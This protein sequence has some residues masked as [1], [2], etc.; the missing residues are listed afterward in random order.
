MDDDGSALDRLEE[1]E[2]DDKDAVQM[3]SD[4]DGDA[5]GDDADADDMDVDEEED[6]EDNDEEDE[7]DRDDDENQDENDDAVDK[8]AA[9]DETVEPDPS[10]VAAPSPAPGQPPAQL[11]DTTAVIDNDPLWIYSYSHSRQFLKKQLLA[12]VDSC[13]SYD[14]APYVAA[15]MSTSI[16]CMD[17]PQS[18][19]WMFTGGQDGFIRK[20]DFYASVN[21]KLQLTVAQKHPF[22][23][24]ITK[25]G[26]LMSYWEN[27]IPMEREE[28]TV[29]GPDE[30][31][32]MRISPVYALA[33][34]S[35]CLWLLS[36][37]ETGGITLQTV[38][39][40]EGRIHE[41]LQ[42]HTSA[43]SVLRLN[44]T[45]TAVISGGWDK[46]VF[47]WD[48]NTG[49]V[50]RSYAGN[51]G[52]ISVVAWRP[53]VAGSTLSVSSFPGRQQAELSRGKESSGI[54]SRSGGADST[55]ALPD[56]NMKQEKDD[57]DD[58]D[59]MG[60]LFGDD[61][62]EEEQQ[63]QQSHQD[64]EM[65]DTS[66]PSLDESVF[67]NGNTTSAMEVDRD[68]KVTSPAESKTN[69]KTNG[70]SSGTTSAKQTTTSKP[71]YSNG[72]TQ[73]ASSAENSDNVFLTASIDG[74]ARLWDRRAARCISEIGQKSA[75]PPWCMNACWS[76]DGN[77]IYFGRRNGVV[78]EYSLHA[79]LGE[80]V[81]TL[82]LP[83]GS[84]PVSCV[85]P[86]PNARHLVCAS[87][88]NIRLYDLQ[89]SLAAGP[90]IATNNF[91]YSNLNSNAAPTTAT[92]AAAVA[93]ASSSVTSKVPFLIVPGH[94]GGTIS[95]ILI[96]PTC[97]YM[98]TAGGNRGWEGSPTEV[99]LVYEIE[100]IM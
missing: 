30:L 83:Q 12:G 67:G 85:T 72:A 29:T 19:R 36:G 89:S 57:G 81:R 70:F 96:D 63:Q 52:Q 74:K 59:S 75:A 47:E 39:H 9:A 54:L 76:L 87:F 98:I 13:L 88:D 69:G 66:V 26:L 99:L 86:M 14:I 34:Q 37:L 94:H 21:G 17:L 35:Q 95:D 82:K 23:D 32:D 10:Q 18:M 1:E 28:S 22:A 3:D 78:E 5:E 20:F 84:G 90:T 27:E 6:E 15:P 25:A 24:S 65:G 91:V 80:P 64:A 49:S 7:E 41:H 55:S 4:G 73:S 92:A 77:N 48:L 93:G 42:A 56:G 45:E 50:V 2:R 53:D 40:A 38:R 43:V 31:Q 60:S 58:S 79:S 8:A 51:T 62:D 11:T 100:K 71:A 68:S 33:V 46:N 16:N 61:E 97:R 44:R